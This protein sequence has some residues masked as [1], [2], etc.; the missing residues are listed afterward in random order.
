[1]HHVSRY[2]NIGRSI[3]TQEVGLE[4][5]LLSLNPLLTC[6]PLDVCQGAVSLPIVW[7][8]FASSVITDI[9]LILVP[10]PMLWGTKLKLIKKILGTFVLGAGVFVLVCSLVKTI[11]VITVSPNDAKRVSFHLDRY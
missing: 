3:Q 6:W 8:T 1:M 7:V 10:L 5:V 4:C 11:F 2:P 9:Y